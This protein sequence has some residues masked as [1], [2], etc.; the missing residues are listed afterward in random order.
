[1]SQT[2][3]F[4]KRREFL[5][6]LYNCQQLKLAP[7]HVISSEIILTLWIEHLVAKLILTQLAKKLL[8][9]C[10]TQSFVTVFTRPHLGPCVMFCNMLFI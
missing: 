6:Q 1:V 3:A 9:L 10:G 5:E 7:C 4:Q 2:F 8:M